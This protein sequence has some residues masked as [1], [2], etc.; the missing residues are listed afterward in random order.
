MM[1]QIQI[2]ITTKS[3]VV[4]AM[5][6]G[7]SVLTATNDTFSGTVLRGLAAARYIAAAGLGENAHEDEQFRNLFFQK[8]SFVDAFLTDTA[9]HRSFPV[10]MSLQRSKDGLQLLDLLTD[11][12]QA[13]FKS[14]RGLGVIDEQGG[15]A[16]IAP[17][18]SISLHMSRSSE[19]ERLAGKS[20]AGGIYNYESLDAGQ[21]F[22]GVIYGEEPDLCQLL[23]QTGAGWTAHVGRSRYTQY[24]TCQIELSAVQPVPVEPLPA[25]KE[26]V[27]RLETP[28]IPWTE[29]LTEAASMLAEIA[30]ALNIRM[31][32]SQFAID[33]R[34]L[35]SGQVVVD[36]FV[37]TWLLRRPRVQALA[38][39][40]VFRL[41]KQTAWTEAD[42]CVLLA[43]IRQ[44]VGQRTAEGF[45]QLRI[46]HQQQL[47]PAKPE[48]QSRPSAA[49][50]CQPEVKAKASAILRLKVL[51]RVRAFAAADA[52][53]AARS[54]P[55]NATHMLSRLDGLLSR[56]KENAAT[57]FPALLE[58]EQRGGNTP[59][60]K[61]LE[62]V[63]I[64]GRK[65]KDI[66]QKDLPKMPY[67]D[68][69]VT[70]IHQDEHLMA[71]YG[72]LGMSLPLPTDSMVFYEYWHWFFRH[73]RKQ[74]KA[75][76][77]EE[78]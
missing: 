31:G 26:V 57:A 35:F 78:A 61:H 6:G 7:A 40:S 52:R 5:A 27:L 34:Q 58:N 39:G 62:A 11:E 59:L 41:V 24:G 9:G 71:L 68:R 17:R 18:K 19:E 13:G 38:A 54:F 46:W 53:E 64:Q 49:A 48:T 32:S 15:L 45:G 72:E 30:E 3:P 44:G 70:S 33:C 22:T 36:N 1:K 10:P 25:G 47:V 76:G 67:A 2:K 14:V 73:S 43:M 4:L 77:G 66:L 16:S 60:A 8:L 42:W 20:Q 12:P 75:K 74:L 28:F 50:I 65:L 29:E 55:E 23:A 21:V 69:L 63:R 51:D 56:C 37:G